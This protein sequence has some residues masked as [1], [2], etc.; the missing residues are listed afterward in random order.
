M[1]G[2][3]SY[4]LGGREILPLKELKDILEMTEFPEGT[5]V[6]CFDTE[7]EENIQAEEIENEYLDVEELGQY[8][9]EYDTFSIIK[10]IL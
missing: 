9:L 7:N 6:W 8:H 3:L 1:Q 10:L 5:V 2:C 4:Y